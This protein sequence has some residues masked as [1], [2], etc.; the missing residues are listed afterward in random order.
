MYKKQFTH[1]SELKIIFMNQTFLTHLMNKSI[2]Q[3]LGPK[4]YKTIKD[5]NSFIFKR[6][7]K[8]Y[9]KT[10]PKI[11]KLNKYMC[12]TQI[13]NEKIIYK[14]VALQMLLAKFC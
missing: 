11:H 12:T 10:K 9:I 6:N 7:L 2:G 1:K 5:Q 3:F 14:C 8:I 4:L 13:G